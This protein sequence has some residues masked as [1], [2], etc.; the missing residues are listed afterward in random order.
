MFPV[1][2]SLGCLVLAAT[3]AFAPAG[4]A[5]E[6]G[7]GQGKF[8]AS[9]TFSMAGIPIGK[10]SWSAEI[11]AGSYNAAAAGR[12]SGILA[13]LVNGVGRIAVRG[14]AADGRLQPADFTSA[15]LREGEKHEL[16]MTL[17]G[18][19]VK[20]L[21]IEGPPPESD[22][23]PVS[24]A[25]RRGIVDPLTA[26]MPPSAGND[27]FAAENCQRMLPIFDGRRRF[28]LTLAFKRID[29]VKADKGYQGPALVCA[30][31]FRPIAGHRASSALLKYLLEARDKEVWFVPVAGTRYLA[32][33][34]LSISN[35]L[36][37]MVLNADAFETT[38]LSAR[39]GG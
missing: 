20:E 27:A 8:D 16:R 14:I 23:V 37:N 13:V 29:K 36:G 17:D 38:P 19:N 32:P 9:Y 6:R 4:E 30:M 25:H 39:A 3:L 21:V 31:T 24:D 34:R 26:L 18:S 33:F 11:G 22:R 10:A 12:A 35:F 28:D 2:H 1:R 5:A 15:I 7:N